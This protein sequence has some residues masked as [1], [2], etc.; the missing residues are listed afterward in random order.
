MTHSLVVQSRP[1][2]K[3]G[4][5]DFACAGD[6][7]GPVS[8]WTEYAFVFRGAEGS[9]FRLSEARP[10]S[11]GVHPIPIKVS[12]RYVACDRAEKRFLITYSLDAGLS[13]AC[14]TGFRID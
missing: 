5:L 10:S 6:A 13:L 12:G 7:C 14:L 1:T 2:T 4:V 9:S 8:Y 3:G 11:F